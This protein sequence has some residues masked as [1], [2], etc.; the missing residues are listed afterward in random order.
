MNQ[1]LNGTGESDAAGCRR[2]GEDRGCGRR[3][4][5]VVG[6]GGNEVIL[7]ER[8]DRRILVIHGPRLVVV[9]VGDERVRLGM[10][11]HYQLEMS[12]VVLD[13][14]DVL[15]RH[16]RDKPDGRGKDGTEEPAEQHARHAMRPGHS[17][18]ECANRSSG[19]DSPR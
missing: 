7:V 5:G 17:E 19:S 14:V 4:G 11:V 6:D 10:P 15:R 2:F 16:Q 9:G 1:P 13:F 18:Q 12:V 8:R 3:W